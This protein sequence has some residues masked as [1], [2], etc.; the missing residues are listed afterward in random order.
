MAFAEDSEVVLG[1]E[2]LE[3]LVSEF[4]RVMPLWHWLAALD[5]IEQES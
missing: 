4:S 5:T 3:L 1:P 2:L